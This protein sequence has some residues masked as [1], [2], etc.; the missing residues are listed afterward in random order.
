MEDKTEKNSSQLAVATTK[1]NDDDAQRQRLLRARGKNDND[2]KLKKFETGRGGREEEEEELLSNA[3]G[4][5]AT[6]LLK[7]AQI[8]EADK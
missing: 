2:D 3:D 4:Q 1:F 5:E 8:S 6:I 7:P